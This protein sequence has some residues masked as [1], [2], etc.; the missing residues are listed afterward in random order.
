M[1]NMG[2]VKGFDVFLDDPLEVYHV[3]ETLSGHVAVSLTKDLAMKGIRVALKGE[4]KTQWREKPASVAS[5]KRGTIVRGA[6]QFLCERVTV[7][8]KDEEYDVLCKDDSEIPLLTAG[9]HTF[10]F[11]FRLPN[12]TNLPCSFECGKIACIRYFVQAN[13]DISWAVDPV[14]ERYFSF[15][16]SPINCNQQKYLKTQHA[17][18]RKTIRCCCRSSGPIA[19]KAEMQR[20]AY[21]PGEFVNIRTKLDNNSDKTMK[22]GVKFI[23]NVNLVADNPKRRSQNGSYEILSYSSPSVLPE[24]EYI[25]ETARM[26]QIP[27]VPT[28]IETRLIQVRYIIEISLMVDEKPELEIYFPITTGNVPYKDNSIRTKLLNYGHACEQSCGASAGY[29]QYKDGDRV[30]QLKHFTPL[31]LTSSPVYST[32]LGSDCNGSGQNGPQSNGYALFPLPLNGLRSQNSL[33]IDSTSDVTSMRSL[34]FAEANGSFDAAD[35]DN[36][37]IASKSSGSVTKFSTR[38]SNGTI[39]RKQSSG[40]DR[41]SVCMISGSSLDHPQVGIDLNSSMQILAEEVRDGYFEYGEDGMMY[42]CHYV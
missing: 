23:Q 38:Q 33:A 35:M 29:M 8:G 19:L 5:D 20:S 10:T 25:L 1:L 37:V 36:G 17:S 21:C 24:Q 7:W 4:I 27:I 16:G 14:A 26:L 22:L 2:A 40:E 13:M 34:N 15:I 6:E 39:T 32:D 30:M 42:E 11:K 9:S 41:D 12:E 28:T 31:Y 18:D 3:G